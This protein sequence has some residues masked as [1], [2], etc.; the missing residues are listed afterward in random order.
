M[1]GK[2]VVAAFVAICVGGC[3]FIPPHSARRRRAAFRVVSRIVAP[4]FAAIA[5]TGIRT[6]TNASGDVFSYGGSYYRWFNGRWWRSSSWNEGWSSIS[7]VPRAFLNI[8]RTHRAYHV[9]KHHP[10]YVAKAAPVKASFKKAVKK[11]SKPG[12]VK[13]AVKKATVKKMLP[14]K[15]GPIMKAIKKK[16]KK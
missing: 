14:K 3:V 1:R 8:P 13:A 10:H 5:S 15:K 2:L 12:L 9:V 6:V 11:A 7:T 16:L 4:A